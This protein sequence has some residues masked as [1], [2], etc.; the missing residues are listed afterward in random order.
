MAAIDVARAR[1]DEQ[2]AD[3][4]R[5]LL[6][7]IIMA[8]PQ[9]SPF[10]RWLGYGEADLA[11][12]EE[13]LKEVPIVTTGLI[14]RIERGL[15]LLIDA[16]RLPSI[17]RLNEILE[18]SEEGKFRPLE[19]QAR[20][21]LGVARRDLDMLSAS[22]AMWEELGALPYAARVRCERA[23]LTGDHAELEAGLAVLER[24][25]DRVQLGRYER[26]AVG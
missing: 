2:L 25:G 15:S 13:A 8:F 10:R 24:I 20:R 4:Y 7:T 18:R 12:V 19:A 17:E 14:E 6:E 5:E 1:E 23:L 11:P 3:V 22:L 16:G 26:L 21:G 9:D